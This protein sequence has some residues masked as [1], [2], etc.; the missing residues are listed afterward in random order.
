MD[1]DLHERKKQLRKSVTAQ[2]K[3]LSLP[4]RSAAGERIQSKLLSLPEYKQ[5]ERIFVY[6]NMPTEPETGRVIRQALADGKCVCVPKCITKTDML[7]VRIRST[8]QLRPGAY[9][10]LEPIDCTETLGPEA[11]DLIV[12]PCVAASADGRRLGHGAGY[13][14]R[15]LSRSGGKTVCLCF[16]TA[17]RADI[18]VDENDI[19]MYRVLSEE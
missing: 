16:Q 17:I 5:A 4:Y 19:R 3:A 11:F 13:Y 15:F 6:V 1:A 14:D 9:G 10:I 7:A 8:D 12:V 2:V 18:P